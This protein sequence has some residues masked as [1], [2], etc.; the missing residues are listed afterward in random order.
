MF[1]NNF[2]IAFI[3]LFTF[4]LSTVVSFKKSVYQNQKKIWK[5]N[6]FSTSNSIHFPHIKS[7]ESSNWIKLICGASN[8]DVPL[9]RNLCYIYTVAG[10]NCIDLSCDLAV[11][12]A[13]K[14]GIKSAKEIFHLNFTPYLMISVNDDEDPHFRKAFFDSTK[15]PID[16]PRPCEKVCPAIAIPSI[17]KLNSVN[18][19]I[20]DKCY[21]CGRCLSIC[22]INLIESQSYQVNY[23]KIKELV[24]NHNISAIEIHTQSGHEHHFQHLWDK[25]SLEIL[26]N[27]KVIAISFPDMNEQTS[28]YLNKLQSIMTTSKYWNQFQGVQIWQADGRPMSGDIGKGTTH[29]TCNLALSILNTYEK[30]SITNSNN[31]N[32]NSKKHYIQLAGGANSY[33][34]DLSMQL[35]LMNRNGFGGYGFGGYARKYLSTY[36][37]QIEEQEAGAKIENY[38]ETLEICLNFANE[39]VNSVRKHSITKIQH[40][41]S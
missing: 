14:D 20:D 4:V 35:G 2:I 3:I 6:L 33:S 9:I 15:C 22:T 19:V 23:E 7:L 30:N 25:I 16:C 5:S 32:F 17:S 38:P 27:C 34:A 37:Q 24:S 8:Q 40:N 11:I 31:I 36:L 21:G 18:G 29:A 28:L 10:V 39:L 12:N 41:T 26:K 1:K 13:A